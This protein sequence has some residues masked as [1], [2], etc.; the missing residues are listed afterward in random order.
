[1]GTRMTS[2]VQEPTPVPTQRAQT[3]G[4]AQTVRT[5]M[6]RLSPGLSRRR[7]PRRM[8]TKAPATAGTHGG[9]SRTPRGGSRYEVRH[10][11]EMAALRSWADKRAVHADMHAAFYAVA[12][13]EEEA[14]SSGHDGARRWEFPA[15]GVPGVDL[16]AMCF[17]GRVAALRAL[18]PDAA[19]RLHVPGTVF[20]TL[21]P[22]EAAARYRIAPA[23]L[24][25]GVAF[26]CSV[27][28]VEP[29]DGTVAFVGTCPDV[30]GAVTRRATPLEALDGLVPVVEGTLSY[31]LKRC[32]LLWWPS[33][34]AP[35]AASE[36]LLGTHAP[37]ATLALMTSI[38]VYSSA[39]ARV[40]R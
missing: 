29:G 4:R 15:R 39:W 20:P 14:N 26:P 22:Q 34:T 23:D 1:L 7:A 27:F 35:R 12:E 21:T 3:E 11:T 17:E 6:P 13:E 24:Y 38:D 19:P 8:P 10:N 5:R 28:R 25:S 30:P 36:D 40:T 31:G 32:G 18:G 2:P 9:K 37:V 33:A 16:A